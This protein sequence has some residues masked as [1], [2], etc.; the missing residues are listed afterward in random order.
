MSGRT[1]GVNAGSAQREVHLVYLGAVLPE[2]TSHGWQAGPS[3]TESVLGSED[4]IAGVVRKLLLKAENPVERA[5][6]IG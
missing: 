5:L 2:G 6:G 3:P 1:H 4:E